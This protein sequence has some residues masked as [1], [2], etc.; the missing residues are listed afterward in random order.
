MKRSILLS[1]VLLLGIQVLKAQSIFIKSGRNLTNYKLKG[2]T[3]QPVFLQN[4]IGQ[5]YEIGYQSKQPDV[6][7]YYYGISLGLEQFNASGGNYSPNNLVWETNYAVLKGLGYFRVFE[8]S[9]HQ[10][11]LKGGLGLATL[12]HGRQEIN[13]ARYDLLKQ[14]EFNGLFLSPQAGVSYRLK[15]NNDIGILLDYDYANQFSVT[16]SSEQK[17]KFIN[18]SLNLGFNVN[19]N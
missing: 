3:N 11:S 5:S 2:T 15:I 9:S 13:G 7:P 14:K 10:L 8:K 18:H 1:L 12:I 17:L 4:E 6:K 16:N 19:I